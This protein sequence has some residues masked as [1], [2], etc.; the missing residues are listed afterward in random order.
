MSIESE[1]VLA[2]VRARAARRAAQSKLGAEAGERLAGNVLD[3][4]AQIGLVPGAAVAGYWATGAEM[5]L[6]PLLQ[7]LDA[8]GVRCGL[9]VVP[10]ADESLVFRVW[11]PGDALRTGPHGIMEPGLEAPEMIPDVMLVPL[12]A[13]DDEGFRLGQG[14]GYYD[15]TLAILRRANP[16][17][18]VGIAYSAQ[19]LERV[20]RDKHDQRLDWIITEVNAQG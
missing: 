6:G 17:V 10:G 4:A 5:P 7:S 3:V 12:V 14:G 8:L 9:P 1:K 19:R 16:V 18:A 15:R 11:R 2:R 20:P 13:F